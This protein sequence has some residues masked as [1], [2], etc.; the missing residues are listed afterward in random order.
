MDWTMWDD[1]VNQYGLDGNPPNANTN[2]ASNG[3]LLNWF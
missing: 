2:P 1:M 3:G